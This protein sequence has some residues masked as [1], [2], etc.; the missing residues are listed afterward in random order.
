MKKQHLYSISF[1]NKLAKTYCISNILPKD[2]YFYW[3]IVNAKCLQRF[4]QKSYPS[5][6]NVRHKFF[7]YHPLLADWLDNIFLSSRCRYA[8]SVSKYW[9]IKS[10]QIVKNRFGGSGRFNGRYLSCV[11]MYTLLHRSF[12]CIDVKISGEILHII[13]ISTCNSLND[14]M[15][16]DVTTSA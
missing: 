4:D 15:S 3:L 9:N 1:Q 10:L 5:P 16:H 6:C 13:E 12:L 11:L 14:V 2:Y 7:L 8:F